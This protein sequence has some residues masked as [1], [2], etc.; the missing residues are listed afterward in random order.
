MAA[1]WAVPDEIS[2]TQKGPTPNQANLFEIGPARHLGPAAIQDVRYALL[3]RRRGGRAA[4]RF[5]FRAGLH[6]AVRTAL[7]NARLAPGRFGFP[8]RIAVFTT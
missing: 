4:S 2:R 1:G 6:T 3:S 5:G 8:L 7:F